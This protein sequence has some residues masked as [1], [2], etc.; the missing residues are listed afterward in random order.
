[1]SRPGVVPV[2]SSSSHSRSKRINALEQELPA[3]KALRP[4]CIRLIFARAGD[5][6]AYHATLTPESPQSRQPHGTVAR[7][8]GKIGEGNKR[9]IRHRVPLGYPASLSDRRN[10]HNTSHNRMRSTSPI[11]ISSLV[12]S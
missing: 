12:R 5:G 1:D 8:Y 7:W 11:V 4:Q 6:R 2:K 10:V 3:L 9:Q